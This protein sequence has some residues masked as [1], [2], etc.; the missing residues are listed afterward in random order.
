MSYVDAFLAYGATIVVPILILFVALFFRVKLLDAI[1]SAIAISVG[2][3]GI[4][5]MIGFMVT[6]LGAATKL[7]TERFDI[8]LTVLDTG[9]S[10]GAAMSYATPLVLWVFV[11]HF[12]INGIMLWRNWTNVL[13]VDLWNYWHFIF[14]GALVYYTTGSIVLSLLAIA[15]SIIVVLK[16]A[17]WGAPIVEKYFQMPG[18]TF[19]H[20]ETINWLPIGYG[21]NKLWS[22]IP[23]LNKIGETQA[24]TEEAGVTSRAKCL[25]CCPSG[26]ATSSMIIKKVQKHFDDLNISLEIAQCKLAEVEQVA[27]SVKPDF[28]IHSAA[29]PPGTQLNCPSWL[30]VKILAGAA[31]NEIFDQIVEKIFHAQQ[32]PENPQAANEKRI[33]VLYKV[34][35]DPG[36]LGLLIG[37][38]IGLL[39][40]YDVKGTL[41]LM[42]QLA[43]VMILLPMMTRK[44]MEGLTAISIGAQN[45][46]SKKFPGRKVYIGLDGAIA[47][48]HPKILSVGILMVPLTLFIAAILPG[49]KILPFA[50]LPVIPI[51]LTW[52]IIPCAG[53]LFRSLLSSIVVVCCILW[54]GT[55]M[56]PLITQVAHQ[57]GFNIPP[58][59]SE[60][61]SLDQGSHLLSFLLWKFFALFGS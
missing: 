26:V 38:G 48:G 11:L 13:N 44:L 15:I 10:V 54:I 61:S 20:L 29:L 32:N 42:T 51:F 33:G 49:N 39:A 6:N 23:G 50:D 36:I 47:L 9:W 14:T 53:N 27:Q 16:L 31:G 24:Q 34:I 2:F 30:G 57:I 41:T 46:M 7:M 43:A 58:G 59:A 55:A 21:L 56:A 40:G 52:V 19:A 60:I 5:L 18:V 35:G 1:K 8:H 12:L 3:I 37:L 28:V 45:Y 25:V 17:D 4:N 22:V